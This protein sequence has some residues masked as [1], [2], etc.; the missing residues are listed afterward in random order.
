MPAL[1]AD[2]P[3]GDVGDESLGPGA[4]E[5]IAAEDAPAFVANA[6]LEQ[7]EKSTALVAVGLDVCFAK[8]GWAAAHS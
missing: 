2:V 6:A 3:V 5:V 4:V 8:D 7:V 1:D